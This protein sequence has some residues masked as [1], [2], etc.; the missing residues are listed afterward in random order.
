M[1]TVISNVVLT[2]K[3]LSRLKDGCLWFTKNEVV[4]RKPRLAHIARVLDNRNRF[5]A[6]AFVSPESHHYVKI[7]SRVDKIPDRSYWEALLKKAF[8][9]RAGLISLT[10]AY[11]VI[12]ADAD[13]IPGVVV[14]K[15]ADV[16]S[17]SVSSSGP[18]LIRD[19]LVESIKTL[20]KP[21]A[22][23]EKRVDTL[24]KKGGFPIEDRLIWG[25]NAKTY[26]KEL[27]QQFMVDVSRGQKTGAYLDYRAIRIKA[28]EFANGRA[29]DAFCY[30][31][32][33]SCQIA[34]AA[35][36]IVSVDSSN[37]AI[38]FA[39]T[40]AEINGHANISFVQADVFEYLA[41]CCEKFDFVHL[42]PPPFARC[43]SNLMAAES[44]YK[45]LVRSSLKLMRP[46]GVLMLSSCSH[47]ISER[48]L[49]RLILFESEKS[50][51]NGEI[52]FRGFQDSDH[53]VKQRLPESLYL[54]AI[55]VRLV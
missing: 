12:H 11:R 31:G 38:S 30:Q 17:I 4:G 13:G 47:A 53:P 3:A 40:N 5:A 20:F 46:G 7:F 44:G 52:I 48:V 50:G 35:K 29:L 25:K 24:Q 14:D 6:M 15:Y 8:A 51:F 39:K 27:D 18:S 22:V 32:W 23:V 55:A 9:K 42:D 10:D 19:D 2:N 37:L 33:F 28:K 21:S 49:E 41:L 54:K 34:S 1:P 45:K 36:E 43:H 26:V 16:W